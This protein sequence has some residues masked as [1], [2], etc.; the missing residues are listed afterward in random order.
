MPENDNNTMNYTQ[1]GNH[2]LSEMRKQGSYTN[3]TFETCSLA[4]QP[5]MVH[6]HHA[7]SFTGRTLGGGDDPQRSVS[8]HSVT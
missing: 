4:F 7:S 6:D 1:P 3:N 8:M 5:A 2:A